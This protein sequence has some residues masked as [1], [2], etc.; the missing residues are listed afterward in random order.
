ME[1]IE[2]IVRLNGIEIR[3]VNLNKL[4]LKYIY[5]NAFNVK[6]IYKNKL[7]VYHNGYITIYN[8]N[9]DYENS[10]IANIKAYKNFQ[11]FKKIIS[12][13]L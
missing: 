7:I 9:G 13:G 3:A 4:T 11:E 12:R 1:K 2:K 6:I 8:K 5:E 10:F